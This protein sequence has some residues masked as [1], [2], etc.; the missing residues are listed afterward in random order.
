MRR[1]WNVRIGA[2][3]KALGISYSKLIGNLKKKNIELDRK[4]LSD[5]AANH[6]KAFEAVIEL[7]KT[8]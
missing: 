6:P 7:A 5:L 3:S 1:L 4:I 2:S 8:A